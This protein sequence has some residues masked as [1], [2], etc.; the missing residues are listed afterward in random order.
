LFNAFRIEVSYSE[1]KKRS[2]FFSLL[3]CPYHLKQSE[4]H[5]DMTCSATISSIHPTSFLTDQ[6]LIDV[7]AVKFLHSSCP[8][9]P[10][11]LMTCSLDLEGRMTYR[12]LQ[13]TPTQTAQCYSQP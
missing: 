3:H 13:F 4:S 9:L 10:S 2:C 8:K 6:H 12:P 7:V 11:R 1:K 5:L